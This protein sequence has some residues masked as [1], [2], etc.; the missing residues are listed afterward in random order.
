MTSSG[1]G[2]PLG[3]DGESATSDSPRPPTGERRYLTLALAVVFV[4]SLGG[5]MYVAVTP[6]ETGQPFTELYILGEEGVAADYPTNVTAGE[7]STVTVGIVSHEQERVEYSLVV[8]SRNRT[9]TQRGSSLADGERW[10][11]PVTYTL[12]ETGPATVQFQLYREPSPDLS[13]EPYDSV[14]LLVNVS[15][16]GSN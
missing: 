15:E 3:T 5:S 16:P 1:D 10:E 7:R 11:E 2:T 13:T 12:E 8:R 9:L 6:Q 14:R 4:L